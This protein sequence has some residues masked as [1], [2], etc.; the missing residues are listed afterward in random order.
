[1]LNFFQIKYFDVDTHGA[2]DSGSLYLISEC[3]GMSKKKKEHYYKCKNEVQK[4][5]CDFNFDEPFEISFD[6]KVGD[7]TK[8]GGLLNWR[9]VGEHI[10]QIGFVVRELDDGL[11]L[12]WIGT[13][14]GG[15]TIMTNSEGSS[16]MS[17][18]GCGYHKTTMHWEN[19]QMI[20]QTVRRN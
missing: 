6:F 4:F 11:S 10:G 3:R 12:G 15:N 13:D 5:G 7:D 14:S 18:I 2:L 20:Y 9:Q 1:M 17:K 8:L 16:H 19:N